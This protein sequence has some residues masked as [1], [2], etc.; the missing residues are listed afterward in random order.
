MYDDH[1]L[2]V[3]S[4]KISNGMIPQTTTNKKNVCQIENRSQMLRHVRTIWILPATGWPFDSHKTHRKPKQMRKTYTIIF[5]PNMQ[6]KLLIQ[7]MQQFICSPSIAQLHLRWY[8]C[9]LIP[10][11]VCIDRLTFL[12]WTEYWIDA[13]W[14]WWWWPGTVIAAWYWLNR[15]TMDDGELM[16]RVD[17]KQ[18]LKPTIQDDADGHLIY[19][20]GDILHNRCSW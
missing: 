2:A 8:G 1:L 9:F 14:W 7:S 15:I 13:P 17:V 3:T 19:R 6:F 18:A 5:K 20:T 10:E 11:M 12:P 16:H 4:A